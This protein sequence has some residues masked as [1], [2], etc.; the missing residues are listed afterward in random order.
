[1]IPLVRRRVSPFTHYCLRWASHSLTSA[2]AIRTHHGDECASQRYDK[3][4]DYDSLANDEMLRLQERRS[5]SIDRSR[6]S[7]PLFRY[8]S[9]DLPAESLRTDSQEGT[10]VEAEQKDKN[11]FESHTKPDGWPWNDDSLVAC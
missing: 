9:P 11:R 5:N 7:A 2:K 4:P 10:G 8:W 3:A 1:M 6:M